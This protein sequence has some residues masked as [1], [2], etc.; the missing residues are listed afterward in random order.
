MANAADVLILGD[1]VIGLS[2][3]RQLAQLKFRVAVLGGSLSQPG[4]ASTAAAGM[5]ST[6]LEGQPDPPLTDFCRFSRSLFPNWVQEL[7]EETGIDAELVHRG[8]ILPLFSEEEKK[9]WSARLASMDVL[10]RYLDATDLRSQEPALLPLEHGALE[11]SGDWGLNNRELHRSLL[12]SCQDLG[13][14]L[15]QENP[16]QRL[17][18]EKG[19]ILGAETREGLWLADE[20]VV[21]AGAWSN[22]ILTSLGES[23]PLEPVRGQMLELKADTQKIPHH[24]IYWGSNY[25]VPRIGK[26]LLVGSTQENAGFE[27]SNTARGVLGLLQM[28]L[29]LL[30]GWGE[31]QVSESWAGFRPGSP[32]GRPFLGRLG[33]WRGLLIAS[34]HSRHGIQLAPGT[35]TVLTELLT[36]G[37]SKQD[38]APFSPNRKGWSTSSDAPPQVATP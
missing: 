36:A 15:R 28:A 37:S 6:P 25:L 12:A 14:S 21:A 16:G 31:A 17:V 30:P 4:R 29:H 34:G 1:G 20:T 26:R 10:A 35:A 23:L 8:A 22:E 13:V 9:H 27:A 24:L 33:S 3:A 18:H 5:L 32:D 2:L 7:R 11:L 19:R 38:L